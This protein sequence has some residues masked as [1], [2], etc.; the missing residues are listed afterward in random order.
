MRYIVP[1]VPTHQALRCTTVYDLT[2]GQILK[3]SGSGVPSQRHHATRRRST[4]HALRAVPKVLSVV[5]E[6][7]TGDVRVTWALNRQSA[8][9]VRIL[10]IVENW[11]N[12]IILR[13]HPP[14]PT[15]SPTP[16]INLSIVTRRHMSHI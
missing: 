15:C 16:V 3:V 13:L 11:K 14:S 10:H 12:T 4:I 8:S 2:R 5:A 6:P 7:V 9:K 1:P